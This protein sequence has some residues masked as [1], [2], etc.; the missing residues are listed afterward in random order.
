MGWYTR[1][2]GIVYTTLYLSFQYGAVRNTW[3]MLDGG[4]SV[5][6]IHTNKGL[7]VY[8]LSYTAASDSVVPMF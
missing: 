4:G 3:R 7:Y 1:P 5:I 6:H 2:P 8:V